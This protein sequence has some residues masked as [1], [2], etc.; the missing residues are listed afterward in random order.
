MKL[1]QKRLISCAITGGI[2]SPTMSPYLPVTSK[3]IAQQAIDAAKAGAGVVHIHARDDKTGMP[4]AKLEDF[5]AIIETIRA[6]NDDVIICVTTGGGLGMTME[7]RTQAI[8][9]FKP[10]LASLN[11][12]SMNWGLFPLA[13]RYK[14]WKHDWE[15]P[16]YEKTRESIFPN[17]FIDIERTLALFDE[18]GVMPEFECYDVGHIYNL[19]FLKDSGYIKGTLYMQFVLGI[20]GA[21]GSTPYDLTVMKQTADR[22]FGEDG[23]VWSAFGAG[24]AEFPI[25]TQSLFMG[26]N[27]RVGLE[28]NLYLSKGV[29]AENNAQLVEKMVRIMGEFSYEPM[30]PSEARKMFGISK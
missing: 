12:G 2:H 26:G 21:L 29:L 10:S 18:N 22:L 19:K 5:G 24:R 15:K 1:G 11:V 16:F 3:D 8:P 27:V 14:E 13:E 23:Y 20:L 25:C 4:S 28:D 9:K 6:A 17:T 30:T 7:Q